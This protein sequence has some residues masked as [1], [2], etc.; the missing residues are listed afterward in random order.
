M[1]AQ[2]LQTLLR[3]L[4]QTASIPLANA[5]PLAKPL[6][7]ASHTPTPLTSPTPED[8]HALLNPTHPE[9]N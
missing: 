1:A 3:F 7:A 6:H 8:L 2:N 4:T 5:L 9:G